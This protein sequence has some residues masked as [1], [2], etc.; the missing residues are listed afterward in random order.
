MQGARGMLYFSIRQSTVGGGRTMS[1]S[2]SSLLISIKR[3]FSVLAVTRLSFSLQKDASWSSRS[4]SRCSNSRSSSSF[5][6]KNDFLFFLPSNS[7]QKKEYSHVAEILKE[8]N[9]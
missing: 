6:D 7:S 1:L 5:Q 3:T 8:K 9:L 2:L 4:K